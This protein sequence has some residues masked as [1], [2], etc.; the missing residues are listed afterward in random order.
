[1]RRTLR[2]GLDAGGV[3]LEPVLRR[4]HR[5]RPELVVLCDVSG[6]MA[7]FSPFTLALLH[8]VHAELGR[9]RS[10]AFVDGVAEVTDLLAG[11]PGVVDPRHLLRRPGV[12]AGDGR[13]DY[14]R[15]LRH[16]CDAFINASFVP[17]APGFS[18]GADI[19]SARTTIVVAGDGRSHGRDPGVEALRAIARRA[20]RLYWFAPQPRDAWTT[21]DCALTS[22]AAECTDILPVATLRELIRAVDRI[23]PVR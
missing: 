13:S 15:V 22:Y 2:R 6:S 5:T 8:A 9:V 20:R 7:T 18:S 19:I 21:E 14:G 1:M 11:T 3:P 4:R 10:F 12:V 16:F 17:F 23:A